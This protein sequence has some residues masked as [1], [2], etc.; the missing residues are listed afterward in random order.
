MISAD[1]R[2]R[3]A[4][5]APSKPTEYLLRGNSGQLSQVMVYRLVAEG[6]A[7]RDV[8]EMLSISDLYSKKEILARILG[9]SISTIRRQRRSNG[10]ARLNSY[11]SAVAFQYAT[12]LEHA[13]DIFGTQRLAEEWLGRKCRYLD[14]EIP[15]DVIDNPLGFQAVKVYLEGIKYGTYQ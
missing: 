4:Q 3:K 14:G 10:Q 9:K 12:V 11:Q 1:T 6:F 2:T 5:H 13:I 7:L 15:L 8:Q